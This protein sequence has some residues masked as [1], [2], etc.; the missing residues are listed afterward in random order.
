MITITDNETNL[1]VYTAGLTL[2]NP[3]SVGSTTDGLV[4]SF[5]GGCQFSVVGNGLAGVLQG[6][7]NN[8]IMVCG[9][10]CDL[11]VQAS[12]GTQATCLLPM[13][14]TSFSANEFKLVQSG[15]LQV[16]WAG[17]GQDLLMLND[18]VNTKDSEDSTAT[19]CYAEVTAKSDHTFSL[20]AVKIFLNDLL[21]KTPYTENNLIL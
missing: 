15:E 11:D 13:L 6:N 1:R 9:N 17:T 3:L 16:T 7:T 2:T 4:C 19:N 12:S 5:A 18:G 10:Q 8:K 20:D 21:N 14:A